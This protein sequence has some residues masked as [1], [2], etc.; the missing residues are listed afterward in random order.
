[1]KQILVRYLVVTQNKYDDEASHFY[2]LSIVLNRLDTIFLNLT[3]LDY[4]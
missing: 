3:T 1:M 2:Q 4:V